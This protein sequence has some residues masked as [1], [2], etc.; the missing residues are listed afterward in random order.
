[1]HCTRKSQSQKRDMTVNFSLFSPIYLHLKQLPIS[2]PCG[3]PNHGFDC[4]GVPTGNLPIGTPTACELTLAPSALTTY[5]DVWTSRL[6]M[7]HKSQSLSSLWVPALRL[8][9]P[10]CLW[11]IPA[12]ILLSIFHGRCLGAFFRSGSN[13][14]PSFIVSNWPSLRTWHL[15]SQSSNTAHPQPHSMYKKT[16]HGLSGG[17]SV[18]SFK[19]AT[20]QITLSILNLNNS[21]QRETRPWV[22]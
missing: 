4:Y 16:S 18:N 12:S 19:L 1:M 15:L 21:W 17:A 6:W 9:S 20:S 10:Q 7:G 13:F 5:R 2:L 14:T 11:N 3:S 22:F 8:E